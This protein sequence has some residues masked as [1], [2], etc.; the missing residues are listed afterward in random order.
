MTTETI[1]TLTREDV[2]A[3]FGVGTMRKAEPYTHGGSVIGTRQQGNTLKAQV[4]GTA[5][6]PYR[7]EIVFDRGEIAHARCSCPVGSG[8]YCKHVAAVLLTWAESSQ[9]FTEVE[10]LDAMLASRSK[11]ELIALVKQMLRQEPDLEDLLEVP[12]PAGNPSATAAADPEAFRRQAAAAFQHVEYGWG[13][14]GQIAGSLQATMAIGEGFARE[15]NHAAAVGV[16]VAVLDELKKHFEQFNDEE[17]ELQEVVN[18]CVS[19]LGAILQVEADAALRETILRALWGAWQIDIDTGGRDIAYEAPDLILQHASTDEKKDVAEW[20]RA[21]MPAGGGWSGDWARQVYGGFLLELEE[22]ELDD[23]AFLRVCRESGRIGDLVDRLLS[24]G[25]TDE[26]IQEAGSAGDYQLLGLAGIFIEHGEGDIAERL[27]HERAASSTDSRLKEWLKDRYKQRGDTAA[28]LG[29]AEELFYANSRYVGLSAYQELRT[30]A[31]E[32]GTWEQLRPRLLET[33]V[34][35]RSLDSL[36]RVHLDEGEIDEALNALAAYHREFAYARFGTVDL[37]VAKAAEE[38][39]P[40]ASI[41]VYLKYAEHLIAGRTRPSYKQA[42]GFLRRVQELYDHT[43]RI[44][45]WETYIADLR[46]RT[47]QLR[48]LKEELNAVGL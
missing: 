27:I 43:G 25:R 1:P 39:R 35:T 44:D 20:V 32:L 47:R 34:R 45:V 38:T 37:E 9:P 10:D 6:R 28:A 48:A 15:S 22:D 4:W 7:V 31:R 14:E 30:L 46:E 29:L 23:E 24:L 8:G 41:D 26:A 12:L 5:D 3:R 2:E 17:G 21:A 42:A 11:E 18:S 13:V 33:F 36:I 19:A 40:D 16:Y